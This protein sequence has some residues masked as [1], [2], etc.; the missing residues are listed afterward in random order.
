AYARL[1]DFLAATSGT[2]EGKALGGLFAQHPNARALTAVI[3]E[4][5]PY[6][7]ELIAAAPARWLALLESEPEARLE[8]LLADMAAA[9]SQDQATA[10]QRWRHAKAEASLL[11]AAADIGGTWELAVITQALTRI[12]DAAVGAAVRHLL[13]EAA[14]EGRLTVPDP[15]QPEPGSGF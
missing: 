9:A 1:D 11:I 12:A 5:S 8:A 14:C 6:L 13:S 2:S 15:A 7:F 3:A 4:G 10:M